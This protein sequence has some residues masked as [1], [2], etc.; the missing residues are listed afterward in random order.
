MVFAQATL[1]EPDPFGHAVA[2]GAANENHKTGGD[3]KDQMGISLEAFVGIV[4]AD[5]LGIAKV[6]FAS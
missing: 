4:V 3:R 1:R 5:F 2:K 6:P